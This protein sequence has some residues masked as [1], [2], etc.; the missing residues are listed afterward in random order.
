MKH[1]MLAET[2]QMCVCVCVC[3]WQNRVE[4]S[5]VAIQA[6]KKT[7]LS[8]DPKIATLICFEVAFW[9]LKDV[10]IFPVV[11]VGLILFL[12]LLLLFSYTITE[13]SFLIFTE[14]SHAKACCAIQ[15]FFV[16][17]L[18]LKKQNLHCNRSTKETK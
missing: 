17:C 7:N 14:S 11:I 1:H 9:M 12:C 6:R 13:I 5:T 2:Q 8:Q 16:V 3:T 18:S 10:S 4:N 15:Q